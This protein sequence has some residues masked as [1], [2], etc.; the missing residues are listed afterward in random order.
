MDC[1]HLCK[2]LV[3]ILAPSFKILRTGRIA[4]TVL[5][6]L[7]QCGLDAPLR[8]QG[9]VIGLPAD[10]SPASR[11]AGLGLKERREVP[12][13]LRASEDAKGLSNGDW[14]EVSEQVG[15]GDGLPEPNRQEER[16]RTSGKEEE[17]FETQRGDGDVAQLE[18]E[19]KDQGLHGS[20]S[21]EEKSGKSANGEAETENEELGIDEDDVEEGDAKGAPVNRTLVEGSQPKKQKRHRPPSILV[22]PQGTVLDAA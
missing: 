7:L 2:G 21:R 4:H 12:D 22:S 3:K 19:G 5:P 16:E 9:P 17:A 1:Y 15:V 11:S 8:L 6:A 10:P 14:E 20:G 13:R 18:T